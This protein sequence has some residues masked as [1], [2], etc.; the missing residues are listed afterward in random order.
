MSEEIKGNIDDV[1]VTKGASRYPEEPPVKYDG[2]SGG[3]SFFWKKLTGKPPPWEG[4]CDAHDQPYAKGGT[5]S[6][7]LE[8]DSKLR[9]CVSDNGHPIWAFLMYY[10][11]RMGGSPRFPFPWRWGFNKPYYTPYEDPNYND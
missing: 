5:R 9:K 6:D 8:A 4:C 11:V 7:R 1:R 10:G 2:C 3:M